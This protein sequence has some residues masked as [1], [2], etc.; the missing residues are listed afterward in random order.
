MYLVV[1]QVGACLDSI[2]YHGFVK[3]DLTVYTYIFEL[4]KTCDYPLLLVRFYQLVFIRMFLSVYFLSVCFYHFVFYQF[5]FYQFVF[6][7]FYQFV[8]ICLFL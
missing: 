3:V 4:Q 8:F 5:A 1:F 6:I 7:N 2:N